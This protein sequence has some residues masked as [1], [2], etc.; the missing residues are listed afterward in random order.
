MRICEYTYMLYIYV[1]IHSYLYTYIEKESVSQSVRVYLARSHLQ[2]PE[3]IPGTRRVRGPARL[4]L[5]ASMLESGCLLSY[6]PCYGL[7][8]DSG[9]VCSMGTLWY[10]VYSWFVLGCRLGFLN[11]SPCF[12]LQIELGTGANQH[13]DPHYSHGQ[14]ILQ[15][16]HMLQVV[17]YD[18]QYRST[19]PHVSTLAHSA[20][21]SSGCIRCVLSATSAH[22]PSQALLG[23]LQRGRR[24]RAVHSLPRHEQSKAQARLV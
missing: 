20:S 1:C 2:E 15:V 18:L 11:W 14:N 13:A 9:L 5:K 19:R 10:M 16:Y 17:L 6:G 22:G 4:G 7:L 8:F 3:G 24:V 12:R 23:G 21:S